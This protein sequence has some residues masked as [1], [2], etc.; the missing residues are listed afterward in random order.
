MA[1]RRGNQE[2]SI[3]KRKGGLWCVQVSLDNHRLT[4]YFKTRREAREWLTKILEH[5]QTG[6]C[7]E[8]GRISLAD[9]LGKWLASSRPSLRHK[10]WMQYKQICRDHILPNLGEVRLRDLRPDQ[11]Q[12]LYNT[13]I[14]CGVSTNTVRILH[15]SLTVLICTTRSRPYVYHA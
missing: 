7:I 13:K 14:E 9:F 8:G 15:V 6:Q 4:R 12:W 11:I 1:K 5:I 3:Y 10:T 2:G